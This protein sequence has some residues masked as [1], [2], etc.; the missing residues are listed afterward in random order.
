MLIVRLRI[1]PCSI[2][3]P[4]CGED[5]ITLIIEDND[6]LGPFCCACDLEGVR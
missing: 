5:M 6:P 3:C 4:V 1:E 2:P